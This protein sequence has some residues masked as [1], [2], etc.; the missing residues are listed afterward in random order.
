M[1]VI[2]SSFNVN[3]KVD[4]LVLHFISNIPGLFHPVQQTALITVLKEQDGSW[5]VYVQQEHSE[6]KD[7]CQGMYDF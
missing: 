5:K 4:H 1:H 7:L 3:G 6:N 2:H